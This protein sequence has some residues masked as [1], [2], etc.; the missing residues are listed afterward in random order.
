MIEEF[1]EG[2]HGGQ[3]AEFRERIHVP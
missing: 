2:I 3:I 1:G